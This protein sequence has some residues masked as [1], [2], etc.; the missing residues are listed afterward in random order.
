MT[1]ASSRSPLV[2][3]VRTDLPSLLRKHV[4]AHPEQVFVESFD[5]TT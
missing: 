2:D 5:G 4:A 3:A 1:S